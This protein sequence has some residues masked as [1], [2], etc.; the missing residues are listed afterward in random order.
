MLMEALAEEE[1]KHF[2]LTSPETSE[3]WP[4]DLNTGTL[5]RGSVGKLYVAGEQLANSTYSATVV[6]STSIVSKG[7]CLLWLRRNQK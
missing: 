3:Y 1:K 7:V 4:N 5:R 6:Q 2:T